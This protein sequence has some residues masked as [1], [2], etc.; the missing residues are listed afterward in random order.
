MP[1]TAMAQSS[2]N[3]NFS[4]GASGSLALDI[5][6]NAVDM[7]TGT[8]Q[9]VAGSSDQGVSAVTNI[10]FTYTLMGNSYTQFS[11]SANG[12]MQ[13][14]ATAVAGATYVASGGSI[15]SPRISAF[16][17]DSQTG[18]N[19]KVHWKLVGSAPNRCLVVEF[20]N[21]NL[22]YV[23]GSYGN[24][25]TYQGSLYENGSLE[26]VYGTMS[27]SN[28]SSGSDVTPSIG[29]STGTAA[30]SF[31]SILYASHAAS[32]SGTFTDNPASVVGN[33][34][35]LTSASNGSRRTYLFVPPAQPSN[36]TA[37]T[38][39]G[40]SSTGQTVNWT[41]SSTNE[42][43]FLVTRATDAGFTA[44]VATS[45]VSSTTNA[46]TGTSYS[47]AQTGLM[48]S[49]LY[50][51]KIQA[52]NEG[53][54]QMLGLS[55]SNST[56]PAGNYTAVASGNWSDPATWS[57]ASVPTAGDNVTIPA[58]ITVTED[59]T[60]AA[61]Y[62]LNISGNLV[63]TATVARTLTIGTDVTINAGGS[64]KSAASGT[65]TTHSLVVGGNLINNG[66]LDFSAFTTSGATLTFNNAGTSNFT[67]GT[68]SVTNL[69]TVTLNKGTSISSVLTFIPGGTL[70]V[71]G[72]NTAGFLTITN[73]LFK[74]DGTVSFSN[75]LFASSSY[76]IP[77]TG[78]F[79]L[80]NPNSAILPLAG[81]PTFSGLFRISGGIFN[82]G[83]A[84]GNSAGF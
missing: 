45:V 33:I 6:G 68:A 46:G 17:G 54:S 64:F 41:D 44:N 79:W 47:S 31:A 15:A 73:G 67:L 49:T 10:G 78:G 56:L 37:L 29:F 22:Y 14:G 51:Y 23:S 9:L 80:N 18:S 4:T 42:I 34:A 62:S 24:D 26:F 63:Y 28:V 61:A 30:N 60:A 50:Y 65:V 7:S 40:V 12:V 69:R 13:L 81:S 21:M 75:P 71:Q 2:A 76:T 38:F 3:Y 8:S 57:P 16:G 59:V 83:T 39:T 43:F 20:L 66:T 58:G 19:G 84:T 74:L 72:A 53:P 25:A 36:P 11:A 32:T 55:G 48:P 77:A 1:R 70:T 52:L 5:N 35:A 82:I 27:V